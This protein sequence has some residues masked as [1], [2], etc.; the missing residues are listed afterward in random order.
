VDAADG[1]T[2]R[3]R[4]RYTTGFNL[5]ITSATPGATIRYTTDGSAPT[6][7][8]G[9]I[10]TVPIPINSTTV[11]RSFAYKQG[12][13]ATNVDTQTYLFI[14][15]IVNQT[16]NTATA[17]GFPTGPIPPRNQ[18]LRYG[19][20]LGNVTAGG[21]TLQD[22]KNALAA[23]PTVCMSTDVA[24]L[25][26]SSTGIYA[27]A[28]KHGLFWERPVP[29]NISTRRADPNSRSI[30]ARVRGYSRSP[31]NPNTP[32]TSTSA[33]VWRRRFEIPALRRE[34]RVAVRPDRYALEEN[35]CGADGSAEQSDARGMDTPHTGRTRPA[36]RD[37]DTPP[38]HQ[39]HLLG[40]HGW[41]ERT[42]AAYGET[43]FGGIKENIDTVKSAGLPGTTPR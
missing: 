2:Q 31:G 40:S 7:T 10:H 32:S 16:T 41:E 22:L 14:N 1:T 43:Y 26:N 9:T 17:I 27:N 21:G 35:Y 42:E 23:A 11:I 33:A 3:V 34:W 29:S 28:D 6:R 39:R 24:N 25:M 5:A 20:T 38:L 8:H 19:I 30:A 12:W 4:G 36:V 13:K 18:V 15:D 37:T